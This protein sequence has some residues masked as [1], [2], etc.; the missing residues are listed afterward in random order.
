M[1]YLLKGIP[2]T[3]YFFHPAH[4][5]GYPPAVSWVQLQEWFLWPRHGAMISH[6]SWA[7]YFKGGKKNKHHRDIKHDDSVQRFTLPKNNMDIKHDG[8]SRCI[9]LSNMAT[10]GRVFNQKRTWTPENQSFWTKEHHQQVMPPFLVSRCIE[11][12]WLGDLDL[13][14]FHPFLSEKHKNLSR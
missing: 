6:G 7:I 14:L 11:S 13:V 1:A 3:C 10:L 8:F 4:H 5:F 2:F 12:S 9:S